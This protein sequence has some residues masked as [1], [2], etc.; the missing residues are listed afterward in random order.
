VLTQTIPLLL[1]GTGCAAGVAGVRALVV[2]PE[3]AAGAGA[4]LAAGVEA[5]DGAGAVV[6]G[7]RALEVLPLLPAAAGAVPLLAAAGLAGVV[8]AAAFDLRER[9][10]LAGGVASA[11]VVAA[12]EPGVAAGAEAESAAAA[13]LDL[14]FEVVLAVVLSAAAGAD[15]AAV[16]ESAAAFLDLRFAVV[17]AA[18][19]SAAAPVVPVAA[20]SA[21]V[22]DLRLDFVAGLVSAALSAGG[23]LCSPEAVAA[24]FERDFF[25]GVA[26]ASPPAAD[27]ALSVVVESAAAFFFFF[28]VVV[29]ESVWPGSLVDCAWT[30][31]VDT[32]KNTA[33]NSAQ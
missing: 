7:V 15:P 16:A 10:A 17:V 25:A 29:L 23:T 33:T 24:F 20:A 11:E 27:V 13:F 14:R 6:A 22:L 1:A 3:F 12:A 2:L 9:L 26:E 4:G 21:S 18:V 30:A 32:A 8:S 19:L 28:L 5:D 31:I